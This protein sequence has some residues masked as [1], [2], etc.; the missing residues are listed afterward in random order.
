D[1]CDH[2][3]LSPRG[4]RTDRNH[5]PLGARRAHGV[6]LDDRAMGPPEATHVSVAGVECGVFRLSDPL[7]DGSDAAGGDR[8]LGRRRLETAPATAQRLIAS[9][10]ISRSASLLC[11]S[12][13]FPAGNWFALKM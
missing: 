9:I 10:L 12:S 8:R 7:A 1:P 2:A 5:H 13:A 4:G 6:A 11:G 3:P